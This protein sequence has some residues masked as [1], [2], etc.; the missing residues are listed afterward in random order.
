MERKLCCSCNWHSFVSGLERW[1]ATDKM[2]LAEQTRQ[3]YRI[4]IFE[5]K[6]KQ[7]RRHQK[8]PALL[9]FTGGVSL[10]VATRRPARETPSAA[11]ASAARSACGSGGWGCAS[12]EAW[13]ETS[14]THSVTRSGQSN[15]SDRR[16]YVCLW[17]KP[18]SPLNATFRMMM[19]KINMRVW[20]WR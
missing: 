19:I 9:F 16:L 20:V 17:T 4:C 12:L 13:K 1:Q 18:V 14:A 15:T 3:G 2:A 5:A 10:C 11:T 8:T 7:T 6:R